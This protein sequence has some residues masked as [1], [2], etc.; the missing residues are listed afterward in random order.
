M[1]A[2]QN[3]ITSFFSQNKKQRTNDDCDGNSG[4]VNILSNTLNEFQGETELCAEMSSLQP[5]RTSTLAP[6][7]SSSLHYLHQQ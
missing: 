1:S 2:K 4:S 6:L 3:R 7:T 5:S